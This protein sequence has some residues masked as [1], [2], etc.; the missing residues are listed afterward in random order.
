MAKASDPEAG[1]ERQKDPSW[2]GWE[3]EDRIDKSSQ[4]RES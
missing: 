1:S 4:M 3:E 2:R